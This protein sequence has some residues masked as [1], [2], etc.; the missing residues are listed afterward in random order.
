MHYDAV[1]P[2]GWTK[3]AVLD[4]AEKLAA[5]WNLAPGEPLDAL[6]KKLGGDVE[7]QDALSV[8]ASEDGSILIDGRHNFRIYVPD[9]VSY[10]RNRFTIAHEIGHYVLHYVAQKLEGQRV[11]AARSS[12]P[13]QQQAVRAEREA[14]WFAFGL[15]MPKTQ[16]LE[17]CKESSADLNS[18]ARYFGVSTQ[19][20]KW[21]LGYYN[22]DTA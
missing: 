16:F 20:A 7:Y 15:L 14:D 1:E 12:Q 8:D 2:I 3:R 10:E 4:V 9:Y 11:K 18:V 6:V 21:Q 5:S 17:G 22:A 19:D 13:N